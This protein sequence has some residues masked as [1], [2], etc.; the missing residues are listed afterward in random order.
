VDLVLL[1]AATLNR[2]AP[3][4]LPAF[5]ARV[6]QLPLLVAV[7]GQFGAVVTAIEPVPPLDG[8][9][10]EEG[11]I[12]YEH[13][14]DWVT[15]KRWPAAVIV[16]VREGPVAAATSKG[17]WA[18]PF[19]LPSARITIQLESDEAVQVH[20]LLDA[21]TSTRPDPPSWG[22]VAL[23]SPSENEHSP[24]ACV[25]SMRRSLRITAPRRTAGS[26]LDAAANS[27]VPSPCPFAPARI[28]SH[29]PSVDADQ[30]HSRAADTVMVPTPPC[31]G[32][33][34]PPFVVTA[35]RVIVVGDVTVLDDDPQP[36][37]WRPPAIMAT[38][39]MAATRLVFPLILAAVVES[40]AG[41]V[42][43]EPCH[44]APWWRLEAGTDI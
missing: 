33:L 26:G 22:K 12:A 18:G 31:A 3:G 35:Q 41:L 13:P 32:T 42:S 36:A 17:S 24:A 23:P 27:T 38:A 16:P 40:T 39:E 4:P 34:P 43:Q 19:P 9:A 25:T 11:L 8:A 30:A 5:S 6:T 29:A 15:A 14:C 28:V 21:R 10:N 1:V 2:A 20:R 37:S 7:H 44:I